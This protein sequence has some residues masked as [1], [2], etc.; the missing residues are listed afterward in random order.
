MVYLQSRR[1]KRAVNSHCFGDIK[2]KEKDV[3]DTKKDIIEKI[4]E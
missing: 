4:T 2:K 1:I 3:W